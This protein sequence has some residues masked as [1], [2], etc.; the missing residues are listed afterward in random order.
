MTNTLTLHYGPEQY[1]IA[2]KA[3]N[4]LSDPQTRLSEDKIFPSLKSKRLVT[5]ARYNDGQMVKRN[6]HPVLDVFSYDD[7][8]SQI[9]WY[10]YNGTQI[11]S[12]TRYTL[13]SKTVVSY[14]TSRGVRVERVTE[15]AYSNDPVSISDNT[16]ARC[17]AQTTKTSHFYRPTSN[18][19][20]DLR[21]YVNQ[22]LVTL[23]DFTDPP[24]P[25]NDYPWQKTITTATSNFPGLDLKRSNG[26]IKRGTVHP[27]PKHRVTQRFK[28]GDR[29]YTKQ[30]PGGT[31]QHG[32]FQNPWKQ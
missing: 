17:L 4:A 18:G 14:L 15:T 3:L 1:K 13:P 7:N 29:V 27:R 11:K 25:E 24:L 20:G 6:G 5:I 23:H 30:L 19:V 16:L 32:Y 22:K 26:S 12:R 2:L 9:D 28:N 31:L 21:P 8:T 10:D